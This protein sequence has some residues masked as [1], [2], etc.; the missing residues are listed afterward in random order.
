[1][2]RRAELDDRLAALARSITAGCRRCRN[3]GDL[4]RLP[5]V[6][7]VT[8][9]SGG[10]RRIQ[11][12]DHGP[13]AR[14]P[15]C[16]LV[17]IGVPGRGPRACG[18]GDLIDGRS[19]PGNPGLPRRT[20]DRSLLGPIMIVTAFQP[21]TAPKFRPPSTGPLEPLITLRDPQ[22][23]RLREPR[24]HQSWWPGGAACQSPKSG[25]RASQ[26]P[27]WRGGGRGGEG[28]WGGGGGGRAAQAARS[29]VV[30]MRVAVGA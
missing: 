17:H 21:P 23:G 28:G 3:H 19:D 30:I 12:G 10:Q 25:P 20:H 1:V 14:E 26:I 2:T 7:E 29:S 18:R 8:A 9:E 13:D 24:D 16:Q 22:I 11:F 6:R 27:R 4:W 5:G 15:G